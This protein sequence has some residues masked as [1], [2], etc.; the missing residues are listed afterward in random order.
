MQNDKGQ[1]YA[2]QVSRHAYASALQRTLPTYGLSHRALKKVLASL[3]PYLE[4]MLESVMKPLPCSS[5]KM[6][7]R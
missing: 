3:R 2:C 5:V 6:W 4:I 7:Q 1:H